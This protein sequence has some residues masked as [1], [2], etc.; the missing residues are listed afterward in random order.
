LNSVCIVAQIIEEEA[1]FNLK[2]QC[3][4]KLFSL[5]ASSCIE[6]NH[7]ASIRALLKPDWILELSIIYCGSTFLKLRSGRV[8][9]NI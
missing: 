1:K 2:M 5:L 3:Y 9:Y 8:I 7:E 6:I 4:G